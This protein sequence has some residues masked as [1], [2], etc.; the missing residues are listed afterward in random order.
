MLHPLTTG[1]GTN[2][3]FRVHHQCRVAEPKRT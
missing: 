1:F 3:K 2:Q